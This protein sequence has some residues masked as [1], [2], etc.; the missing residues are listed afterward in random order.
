MMSTLGI[1]NSGETSFKLYE[2]EQQNVIV[3]HPVVYKYIA[4]DNDPS[5]PL[6]AFVPG[7]AHNGRISYGGHEGYR[8]EEFLA[9]WFHEHGYGFLGISYP[10]DAELPL[11]SATSPAFT[12]P[13][14][15]VQTAGTIKAVIEE[16]HLPQSVVILAWSMA[17][18][19]LQP[20]TVEARRLGIDVQLFIS[21][22]ATPSLPGLLPTVSKERL[23]P[24]GSGYLSLPFLKQLFL[25]QIDEQE[26]INH[27]TE[28]R[29]FIEPAIYEK[30]YFGATP[31][32][33]TRFGLLFDNETKEFV[34][35]KD[36]W[37]L[38]ED[39][40]AH[41]YGSLPTMAA[42]YPTSGLDFRHSITDKATW[43]Y[44]MI[45]RAMAMFSEDD[46][47]KQLSQVKDDLSADELAARRSSF[48]HLQRIVLGIPELMTA[49]I[50]GNHFFFCGESGAK[51]T[52]EIVIGFLS[53]S[54]VI[55]QNLEDLLNACSRES[56]APDSN[57]P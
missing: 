10:L 39:G 16:N 22:A 5:K 11:M 48:Q 34:E 8:S 26:K 17:G 40:Q 33:I 15:G 50:I 9:H 19:V 45:Q 6:V 24:T 56:T 1:T 55:Q 37:Q 51:R 28:G 38:L 14:W 46:R 44:L 41:N 25:Q 23:N 7:M 47:V 12:I 49:D 2:G 30:E 20:V 21:L 32:G 36:K 31:I 13:D 42:I 27:F 35:E 43:S 4:G 54:I 57:A 29:R 52:V 18:K 53:S 3:G